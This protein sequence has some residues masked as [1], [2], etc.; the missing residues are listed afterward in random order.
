M[1]SCIHSSK[2]LKTSDGHQKWVVNVAAV[3]GQVSTSG[4]ATSLTCTLAPMH[5]PRMAKSLYTGTEQFADRIAAAGEEEHKLTTERGDF[6]QGVPTIKVIVDG[7]W[8]KT[9]T[10]M[11]LQCQEW[12][13][14][15]LTK[16]LCSLVFKTSIVL[17]V[18]WQRRSR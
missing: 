16:K 1:A 6:H 5:V 11:Q 10:Q 4:G 9:L 7:G 12:C 18:L 3:L 2:R 15:Q 8:S 14:S 13:C 17:F